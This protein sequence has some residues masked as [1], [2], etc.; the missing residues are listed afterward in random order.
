MEQLE[1]QIRE[2]E[3]QSKRH[4]IELEKLE[5]KIKLAKLDLEEYHQEAQA[6]EL[7]DDDPAAAAVKLRGLGKNFAAA[8]CELL[9]DPDA[10]VD[11]AQAVSLAL[12]KRDCE[13]L[14]KAA[15][16]LDKAGKLDQAT[17]SLLYKLKCNL[18]EVTQ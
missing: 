10:D 6:L 14:T 13:A 16:E 3:A 8:L 15:L 9:A 2:F 17:T 4:Q 11:C 1:K 18:K 5:L 12:R 7:V